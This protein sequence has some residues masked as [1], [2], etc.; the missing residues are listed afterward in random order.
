[1]TKFIK[2]ADYAKLVGKTP[3]AV[4]KAIK[5][6]RIKDGYKQGRR[7]YLIDAEV[8]N[9]EWDSNTDQS[10]Q[11]SSEVIRQGQAASAGV[12]PAGG[13]INYSK[14]RAVG[15]TY[16]ARLLE[17]EYREKSNQLIPAD[18][19][20][21]AQFKISRIFRDAVQNIPVRV[22]SEL[23]AIVG[24]ISTEKRHEMMLVMQ[25]EIDRSLTQ[26][27]EANGTE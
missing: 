6:G 16:K 9:R 7:G 4:R 15:E 11:R 20:K 23:A 17:L 24:D 8:A 14:A 1:M 27:A 22:V 19:A 10:Q 2:L 5:D 13:A 25:R 21:L 12:E 26:L 18:D 3:Q